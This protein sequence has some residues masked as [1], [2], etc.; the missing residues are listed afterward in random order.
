MS[1]QFQ[2]QHIADSYINHTQEALIPSLELALVKD[3]N[4]NDRR[5]FDR[6]D[7]PG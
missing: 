2:I 6:S 1:T 4:S 5:V 3:L 7:Y